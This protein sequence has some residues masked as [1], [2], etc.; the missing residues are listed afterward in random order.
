MSSEN[1]ITASIQAR[2]PLN[3]DIGSFAAQ[4][5]ACTYPCQ[6]RFRHALA[7]MST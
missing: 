6:Q 3:K 1:F 2:Y 7:D 4:Y 5:P